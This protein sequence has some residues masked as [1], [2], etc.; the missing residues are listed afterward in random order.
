MKYAAAVAA[1]E[2]RR[3]IVVVRVPPSTWAQTWPERPTEAV[4]VGLR[5]LSEAVLSQVTGAAMARASK[6]HPGGDERSR[7]WADEYNRAVVAYAVAR[8][9]CLPD[10]ADVPWWEYQDLAVD[11]LTPEGAAWL[12]AALTAAMVRVSP[13]A[14]EEPP[15]DL[16]AR[17]GAKMGEVGHLPPARAGQVSRLLRAAL[18]VLTEGR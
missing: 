16:Y 17:L 9:L 1:K 14:A 5:S 13:L 18:D 15:S 11:R 12:Y 7:L 8:A 10:C 2:A 6:F 3:P 4:D